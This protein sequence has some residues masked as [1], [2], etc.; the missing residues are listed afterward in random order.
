MITGVRMGRNE[1]KELPC[2]L[3]FSG[4]LNST[5]ILKLGKSNKGFKRK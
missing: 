5:T 2:K 1:G 4:Y 3:L